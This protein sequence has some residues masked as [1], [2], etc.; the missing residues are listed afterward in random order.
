MTEKE[1]LQLLSDTKLLLGIEGNEKDS[2]IRFII[3]DTVNAVLAY[4]R[5]EFLP[6]QLYSLIVQISAKIYRSEGYFG[7]E[8][9]KDVVSLEEGDRKVVYS[10]PSASGVITSFNARL[11]PFIS[12]QAKLP[13][14]VKHE[15]S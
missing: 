3:E 6:A 1:K 9:T 12:R 13:S 8:K 5:L 15:N 4:C 11:K 10:Y 2:L 14:E 7:E